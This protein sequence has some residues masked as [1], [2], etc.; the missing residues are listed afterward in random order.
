MRGEFVQPLGCQVNKAG[1]G[2]TRKVTRQNMQIFCQPTHFFLGLFEAAYTYTKRLWRGSRA[3][4]CDL[5]VKHVIDYISVIVGNVCLQFAS[6]RTFQ[7]TRETGACRRSTPNGRPKSLRHS[8]CCVRRL[9][10]CFVVFWAYAVSGTAT[11]SLKCF[12]ETH[13]VTRV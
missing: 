13:E 5:S 7:P 2:N 11:S 4:H 3:L 1:T 9:C 8:G 6:E 12:G 10:F